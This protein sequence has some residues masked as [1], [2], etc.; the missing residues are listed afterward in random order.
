[1]REEKKNL[2]DGHL[3]SKNPQKI[4]QNQKL[5]PNKIPTTRD[6]SQLRFSFL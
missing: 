2:Q 4:P 3:E 5:N 1:M 6:N